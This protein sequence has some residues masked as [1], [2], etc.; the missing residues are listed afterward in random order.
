M[1]KIK[2]SINEPGSFRD[3]SGFLFYDSGHI[4]R[5]INIIYKKDYDML[6]DSGLY[7]DLTDKG[8]LINH[9]EVDN[10][11]PGPDKA[12]KIIRPETIPFISYPYEWCFDQLKD[13]ALL[14]FKIQKTAMDF[15]MTLKDSSVYNVQFLRGR[16]VFID[17]LSFEKYNEGS[18]WIAYRQAC[19]H[20]L[21]PLALMCYTDIRLNQLFRIY[22]DG[23]PLDLASTLLPSSTNFNPSLLSHIHLH[24]KSQK[25][26]ADKAIDMKSRKMS[27]M[28]FMGLVDSLEST[29]I[30]LNH[31]I[32]TTEWGDYYKDTNYSSEAIDHKSEIV[33]SFLDSTGPGIVWDL[34]A[35]DGSFSRIASGRGLNTISFDIDP[36]AVGKNYFQIKKNDEKNIL[37]LL[38]DLINPSPGIG[39]KNDERSSLIKRGPA[40]TA[41]ALALIHHLAISN[42]LPLIKIADF[43][44]LICNNLIIEFVPKDDSQ[45]QRLLSTRKD[46]FPD[47]TK[48][49]FEED[50]SKYFKIENIEEIK[51][52]RRTMYLMKKKS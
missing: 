44:S 19:Q 13:A 35:N 48:E 7:K 45:V 6:M 10:D 22:M 37:P 4:Y 36:I 17:T 34:G 43:F 27:R 51:S 38:L 30:R 8:L 12:Y 14:T 29:I 28:S 31:K 47:Y 5:Q 33:A 40:E 16:P 25:H 46:I 32:K 23:I 26:Y 11:G 15:G 2:N 50:F 18:P 52:S 49:S 41:F 39:W 20:F 42:N 21:A 24:A 1:N 3:P 9:E